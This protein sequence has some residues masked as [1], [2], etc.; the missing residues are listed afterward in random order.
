MFLRSKRRYK[1]GKWHRYFSIVENRRLAGDRVVQR[2]VLYL[3]EINGTQEA[4][5]HKTLEVFDEQRR[6]TCQMSLFPEDREIPPDAVNAVSLQIT[7]LRLRRCRAFGDCWLALTLWRELHLDQFWAEHFADEEGDV[8]WEQVL[9]ILAIN[10]LVAPGSEW[11]VHRE[12]FLQ[13][14]LD[15]LLGVDFA[16]AAKDRLYRCLD[17]LVRH[18]DALHRHLVERWRTLFDVKFDVLL[19]DLTST[20]FEGLGEQNSKAKHGYSRDGR[21]DCR[22]VVIALIVTPDGLPLAYEVMPGNTSDRTTLRSFLAR[23]ELLY[24]KADRI[25]V[26]DRGIPTEEILREMRESGIHYLVGTPKGQL[27]KLEPA[28]ANRPWS[29][30]HEALAVKLIEQEGEVYVLARSEDRRAKERA[31]RRRRLKRL[32]HGLN[33]LKRRPVNRDLLLQKIGALRAEAG[34]VR[35]F[36]KIR[37]PK[38]GEAVNRSTFRCSFDWMGWRRS[39]EREGAYVLRGYLPAALA[40]DGESL[41]RMYMQLVQ[42][43]QAFKHVKGDLAIRPIHHSL[44]ERVEAHI[45]V[46]FLGYALLAS[47]RMKLQ[48]AAPGLTPRAVLEKLSTIRMVDVC[49]P[50]TDGRLLV[51]PRYVEPD[52]DQQLVLD[53]LRLSLPPQPP[54]R[55][56]SGEVI[57]PAADQPCSADL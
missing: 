20:Y 42:V 18:K 6:S 15:E 45:L 39:R 36:V 40:G 7:E 35:R 33:V 19:Y 10:R 37:L 34:L 43:E 1:N 24:G 27:S 53:K 29:S 17:R 44:E 55:I 49:I 9:A 56:R 46:A 12:W 8:A 23:I 31:I 5:W 16:A 22:Q 52:A 57:L 3:G 30:V 41:W 4:A 50:T 28:L 2:Q 32:V 51:M 26:M 21:P 54:P 13:T 11:R 25:W 47:L 38:E 14:A 48:Y